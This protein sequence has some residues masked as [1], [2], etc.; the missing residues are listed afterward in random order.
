[1]AEAL[2]VIWKAS[3][4]LCSKRLQPFLGEMVK[5]MRQHGE[6]AVNAGMEAELCRMSPSTIDWVLGP[7]RRLGGRV[8]TLAR[9]SPGA[10]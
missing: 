7:Y 9:P 10:C 5:V 1:V 2:R 6:P 4:R 3:D 8:I